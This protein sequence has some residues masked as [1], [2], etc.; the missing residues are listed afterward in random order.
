MLKF[1]APFPAAVFVCTNKRPDGSP[2]PCCADRGGVELREELKKMSKE[3][4]LETRVKIFASGCLGGCE[5][6]V[7]A[8]SYP[9]GNL[10]LGVKQED[11][12]KI[13]DEA[14]G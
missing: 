11:L 12:Q 8:V 13:L 5:Q 1:P 4:G 2:K 9:S 10:M 14:V 3:Q 7:V 6:G